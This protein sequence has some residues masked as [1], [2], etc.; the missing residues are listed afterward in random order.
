METTSIGQLMPIVHTD[1]G[2]SKYFKGK[3]AG[4]CVCRAIAIASG[5]DYKEVY[6]GLRKALGKT[7]RDGVRTDKVAFKRFMEASGFTWTPLAGIGRPSTT[8]PIVGEL[9]LE[10]R[11]VCSACKHYFAVID[12][13]VYDRWDSRYNGFDEIRL[14][15]GYWKF[16]G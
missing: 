5:R 11:L 8:H 4:D 1:G 7:P 10:G 15:Y 14:V 3:D 12:S 2:R 13:V 9:P 6:D 16:N